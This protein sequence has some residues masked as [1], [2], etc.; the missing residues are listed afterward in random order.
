MPELR[1]YQD[2]SNYNLCSVAY[3]GIST[4]DVTFHEIYFCEMKT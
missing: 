3:W 2:R 4:R 1:P